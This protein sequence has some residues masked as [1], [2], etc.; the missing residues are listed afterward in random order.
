MEPQKAYLVVGEINSGWSE[1]TKEWV[2]CVTTNQKYAEMIKQFGT[3][4]ISSCREIHRTNVQDAIGVI[5][6]S[7]ATFDPEL[8]EAVDRL[9][10]D[11]IHKTSYRVEETKLIYPPDGWEEIL[12]KLFPGFLGG[13]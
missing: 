4:L 10:G 2:L 6:K 5:K 11:T 12:G 3:L 1:D 9:A 8:A 7:L 13:Q